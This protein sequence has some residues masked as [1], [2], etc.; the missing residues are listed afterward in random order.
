MGLDLEIVINLSTDLVRDR[1]FPER[2]AIDHT[3]IADAP[4][5]REARI[6]VQ[7]IVNLAHAL[8]L[9]VCAEGIET[10]QMFEFAASAGF[11]TAQG[12]FFSEPVPACSIEQIVKAW[13]SAGPAGTGSWRLPASADFDN[14]TTTLRALGGCSAAKEAL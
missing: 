1:A 2:L 6:V 4:R 3:L 11:D 9:G 10:R 5:E 7:A 14:A 13:P 12:R 8:Q